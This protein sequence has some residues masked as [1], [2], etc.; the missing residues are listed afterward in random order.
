MLDLDWMNN[1][2]CIGKDTNLF[3]GTEPR[4]ARDTRYVAFATC[5][6]C[7]VKQQCLMFALNHYIP[8]GIFGGMNNR[9][10]LTYKRKNK[11]KIKE[12][13]REYV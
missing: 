11:I 1:A 13:D 4:G 8:Y 12:H 9:Q 7:P 3:F 5:D 10:R 2:A 6:G